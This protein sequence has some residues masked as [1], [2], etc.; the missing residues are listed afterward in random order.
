MAFFS[1]MLRKSSKDAG[2]S[3]SSSSS[4]LT[5]CLCL[6]G[7]GDDVDDLD[8]ANNLD[9][10]VEDNLDDDTEDNLDD[11]DFSIGEGDILSLADEDD[12]FSLE[13]DDFSLDVVSVSLDL[14]KP[15]LSL[16]EDA[17]FAERLLEDLSEDF[18]PSSS[19]RFL[20]GTLREWS[21]LKL[22]RSSCSVAKMESLS[23]ACFRLATL[24]LCELWP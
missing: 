23:A 5:A 12:C 24:A 9:D 8:D 6:D 15:P 2:P 4:E 10:D 17:L 19:L 18:R 3:S 13:D 1:S 14:A 16:D 22:K 11:D 7:F 20:A 21:S